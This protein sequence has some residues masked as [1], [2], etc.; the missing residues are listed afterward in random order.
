MR[1]LTWIVLAASL[2]SGRAFA[3]AGVSW[4]AKED[5]KNPK[6]EMGMCASAGKEQLYVKTGYCDSIMEILT[7][8]K[9]CPPGCDPKKCPAAMFEQIRDRYLKKEE[10]QTPG[11]SKYKSEQGID[12][13]FNCAYGNGKDLKYLAKD[14]DITKF[15]NVFANWIAT[16]VIET[17][18]WDREA[19][20]NDGGEG[21]LGLTRKDMEDPKYRC[22]CELKNPPNPLP[23]PDDGHHSL[24]CGTYIAMYNIVEDGE[25]LYSGKN[26]RP[27]SRALSSDDRKDD[28]KGAA[29]IFRILEEPADGDRK[30]SDRQTKMRD[31]L[32]NFCRKS[33]YSPTVRTFDEDVRR[34]GAGETTR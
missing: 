10:V 12:F 26:R 19:K 11:S 24:T 34:L 4:A 27:P 7:N 29:R 23:G 15:A 9:Y 28:R 6:N 33:A 21:L 17:S 3:S 25:S 32:D 18:D 8:K 14:K 2:Q 5:Y 20:G 31:K 16:I 30:M 22:G 1:V 13:E